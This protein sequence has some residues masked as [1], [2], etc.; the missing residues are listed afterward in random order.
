MTSYE[1]LRMY[2]RLRGIPE[3]KIQGVVETE[4]KRLDLTKH[5]ERLCGTYRC[6]LV[7]VCVCP[8][9]CVSV[10]VYMCVC[11]Y[12]CVVCVCLSVCLSLCQCGHAHYLST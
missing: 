7:C 3:D 12:V 5:A 9:L 4:I 1:L 10:C 11:M 6:V 2:A 8:C